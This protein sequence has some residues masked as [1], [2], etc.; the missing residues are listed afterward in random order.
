LHIANRDQNKN[1]KPYA[2][3][4]KLPVGMQILGPQWSEELILSIA[5]KYEKLIK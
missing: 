5:D 4:H 1:D 2:I 3:S